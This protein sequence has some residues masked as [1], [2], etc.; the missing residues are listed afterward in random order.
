ML[1][2][3]SVFD[4]KADAFMAPIFL[5]TEGLAVRSFS[6]ACSDEGS[7]FNRFASDY[8]LFEVGE[9]DELSGM[10]KPAVAPRQ[11]VTALVVL[12]SLKGNGNA[13]GR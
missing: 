4:A 13:D 8:S 11:V 6:Q 10:L 9:F 1:K 12:A 5:K 3:F 2:A 7:D